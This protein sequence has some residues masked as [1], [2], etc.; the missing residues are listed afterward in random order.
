MGRAGARRSGCGGGDESRFGGGGGGSSSESLCGGGGG[1]NA[2]SGEGDLARAGGG[3][4]G[5]G[6]GSLGGGDGSRCVCLGG[7][8]AGVSPASALRTA[9]DESPVFAARASCWRNALVC[10]GSSPATI[11]SGLAVTFSL[12]ASP[13]H[14]MIL[15]SHAVLLSLSLT[16]PE[17]VSVA[18][19]SPRA[20]PVLRV[21]SDT[22][23][24]R[25]L[26]GGFFS[27][28]SVSCEMGKGQRS[29][30]V[31]GSQSLKKESSGG[32]GEIQG[33]A[34]RGRAPLA[35]GPSGPSP[36]GSPAWRSRTRPWR[37]NPATPRASSSAP[38]SYR[39]F[40]SNEENGHKQGAEVY[41]YS[42]EENTRSI[43]NQMLVYTSRI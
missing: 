27:K 23:S 13:T 35:C 42:E 32:W 20:N 17:S 28:F 24:W 19:K 4:G 40:I 6:E 8:A 10:S 1:A 37:P 18:S 39:P 29:A 14:A 25:N 11:F 9:S 34:G 7:A 38:S 41:F 12:S 21:T 16:L 22:T 26:N 31:T 2:G 30:V 5:G 43:C 3:G 33:S 15:A 36:A